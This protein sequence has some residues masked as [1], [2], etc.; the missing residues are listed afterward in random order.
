MALGA[1]LS[2]ALRWH[3]HAAMPALAS[4]LADTVAAALRNALGSRATATLAVS[5][6][7]TPALFLATLAMQPLD[8][9]RVI[10]TLADERWVPIGHPRANATLVRDTLLQGA[11][12]AACFVPLY[13]EASTPEAGLAKVAAGID[14]LPLPLDAVVLGMGE[15]GHV[16]SLFPDGDHL[17]AALDPH[18]AARVLPMCAPAADEPRITLTLPVLAG[19]RALFLLITGDCKR[20]VLERAVDDTRLPVHALL[21]RV[22]TPIAVYWAP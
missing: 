17:A 16:A 1:P 21:A 12:A 19:A 4:A 6:G 10:V 20:A 5:G 14:A 15:D 3:A 22:R 9:A 8:W 11:A 2:N 13:T 18:A 7:T